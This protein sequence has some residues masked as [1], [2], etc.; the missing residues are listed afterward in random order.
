MNTR[1]HAAKTL[2]PLALA[3]VLVLALASPLVG[4]AGA[5]ATSRQSKLSPNDPVTVTVWN[6][7]TGTQLDSFNEL[8]DEFNRTRGKELGVEVQSTSQGSLDD[9][10]SAVI[11]A[12]DKKVGAGEVPTMFPAYADIARSMDERGIVQDVSSYLTDSEKAE[13]VDGYLAEGDLDGTGE[14]KIFPIAK[15]TEVM[16]LNRTDWDKFAAATGATTDDLATVEGVARTAEK[17][18]EWTDGLTPAPDDGKALFGR[19]AMANYLIIGSK[20]LG[21]ELIGRNADG[22]AALDFDKDVARKLWDNYYLPYLN[23]YYTASGRF[24][25]DDMKTGDLIAYVGSSASASF[26]PTAVAPAG[27]TRYSIDTQMLP[28]P[29]FEGGKSVAVQQGAGMV[30]TKSDDKQVEAAVEFLKWFTQPEHNSKFALDTSY[31]PVKKSANDVDEIVS[32]AGDENTTEA[33]QQALD[34]AVST[35]NGNEMYTPSPVENGTSIRHVLESAL[36]DKAEA[37]RKAV[38]DL[39]AGGTRRADAVAK[40]ATDANFEAWYADTLAKLEAAAHEG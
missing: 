22:T 30:V 4:C 34:A 38:V 28:A 6:Y 13:Y 2:A 26:T 39:M 10:E 20:Q 29:E 12:A 3:A 5:L 14:L 33:A 25:S 37:D 27:A 24:R 8:V 7:Y 16:V 31:L 19:D 36:S 35:V 40:Y 21:H 23:G 18:Y 17:Y 11:A 9:L 15:A 1:T 32:Y